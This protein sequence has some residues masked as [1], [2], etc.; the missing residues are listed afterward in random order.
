VGEI[1]QGGEGGGR[2]NRGP[3]SGRFPLAVTLSRRFVENAAAPTA[4]STAVVLSFDRW[5]I[6]FPSVVIQVSRPG[7]ARPHAM[8]EPGYR[9][10]GQ[11]H[12][13]IV[14]FALVYISA[15]TGRVNHNS[16]VAG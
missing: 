1:N 15:G 12:A 8:D 6:T 14:Y 16:F 11:A 5:A 3:S 7:R 9:D 13:E 2:A 10:A 4:L